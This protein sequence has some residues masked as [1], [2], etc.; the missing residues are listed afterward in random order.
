MRHEPF[1]M[2]KILYHKDSSGFLANDFR[3]TPTEYDVV[4]LN[5]GRF[6]SPWRRRAAEPREPH[7]LER[8]QTTKQRSI[9]R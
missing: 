7:G 3:V 2:P 9:Q 8:P 5:V 1:R 6:S 4:F